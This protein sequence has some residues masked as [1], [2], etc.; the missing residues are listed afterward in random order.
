[1]KSKDN[2]KAIFEKYA[3][4][5]QDKYMSVTMY[6]RSLNTLLDELGTENIDILDVACGPGNI[7][8]YLLDRRP[9][10]QILGID[11]SEKMIALA[12]KNNPEA[13]FRVL[14]CTDISEIDKNFDAIVAGFCLPYLSKN[15]VELFLKEAS[16]ILKSKSYLY[17]SL[18]EDEYDKSG[19]MSSSNNT[20]EQLPTYFYQEKDLRVIASQCNL[21]IIFTERLE[22]RNNKEGVKDLVL[23]AQ[24]LK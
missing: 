12:K 23:I 16:N 3:K 24:K 2:I 4:A 13:H 8:R 22:N 1:M 14:D 18:M 6:S 19:N 21:E 7:S 15:E 10:L 9:D 20:G 17:L 11:I 5:Y